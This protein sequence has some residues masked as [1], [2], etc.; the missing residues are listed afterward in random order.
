MASEVW[1][2]PYPEGVSWSAPLPTGMCVQGP[3]L[4]K[5]YRKRPEAAV[6]AF[7]GG[8]FHTGDI[9]VLDN[10][11]FLALVRRNGPKRGLPL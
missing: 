1:E 4:T 11:G 5:S 10:D 2:R 8:G 3:Q 6:A 9:G 7:A